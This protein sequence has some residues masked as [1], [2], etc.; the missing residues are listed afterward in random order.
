MPLCTS[1]SIECNALNQNATI[2]LLQ[3]LES[4]TKITKLKL[5][6]TARSMSALANMVK[7][8][9]TLERIHIFMSNNWDAR[10]NAKNCLY[11]LMEALKENSTLT[12]L[13]VSNFMPTQEDV[14]ALADML[15]V[16]S[17]LQEFHWLYKKSMRTIGKKWKTI[18]VSAIVD[19]FEKNENMTL[20]ALCSPFKRLRRWCKG[21]FDRHRMLSARARSKW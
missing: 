16:N 3:Q 7:C 6:V 21:G 9:H 4:N 2:A 13:K 19:V 10:Q 18:D 5:Y 11:L 1:I 14:H 20:Q 12:W 8:N 17:T 15:R